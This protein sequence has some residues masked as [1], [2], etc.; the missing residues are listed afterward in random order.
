M[1][2]ILHC[3]SFS[4]PRASALPFSA[5]SMIGANTTPQIGADFNAEQ[6]PQAQTPRENFTLSN[7]CELPIGHGHN[8]GHDWNRITDGF[9]GGWHFSNI[10]TDRTGLPLNVTLPGSGT[11]PANNQTYKFLSLNGGTLRPKSAAL[12]GIKPDGC[13][14]TSVQLGLIGLCFRYGRYSRVLR[15]SPT[16]CRR[17]SAV[18]AWFCVVSQR[19]DG[20]QAEST[21][22]R[23]APRG[24]METMG[25][26]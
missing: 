10:L 8:I 12:T 22:A 9:L 18:A 17:H 23:R 2:T 25:P 3:L 24:R 5:L 26:A 7:V 14:L 19:T 15:K 4:S 20:G 13:Q 11:N 16:K 21:S 1:K 6:G